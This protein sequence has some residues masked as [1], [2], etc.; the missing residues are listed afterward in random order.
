MVDIERDGQR[1]LHVFDAKLRIDGVPPSAESD[2]CKEGDADT[3]PMSFKNDDI[4]KMHAYRDARV[5][6][7]RF[8]RVGVR[9]VAEADSSHWAGSDRAG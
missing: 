3:N 4:A 6:Y 1:E 9:S 2:D 5:H 7:A 8:T